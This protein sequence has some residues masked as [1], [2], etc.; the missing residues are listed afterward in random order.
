MSRAPMMGR[1]VTSARNLM[2]AEILCSI[3]LLVRAVGRRVRETSQ[4]GC[5]VARRRGLI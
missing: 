4:L 1:V 2:P 5:G 3:A